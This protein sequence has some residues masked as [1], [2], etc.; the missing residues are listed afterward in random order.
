MKIDSFLLPLFLL[1]ITPASPWNHPEPT[2]LVNLIDYQSINHTYARAINSITRLLL[3]AF[4]RRTLRRIPSRERTSGSG[5]ENR[6]L[7]IMAGRSRFY[8]DLKRLAVWDWHGKESPVTTEKQ[9][10]LKS[11]DWYF[12]DE[13]FMSRF[14]YYTPCDD[15]REDWAPF[16]LLN[17]KH[18]VVSSLN[19]T[20]TA[21]QSSTTSHWLKRH[22]SLLLRNKL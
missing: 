11:E 5:I 2:Q 21:R 22:H 3:W 8:Y 9:L 20:K 14:E 19:Q 13:T 4:P 7:L 10:P 6:W 18:H 17:L 16:C 1:R 12:H 15:K